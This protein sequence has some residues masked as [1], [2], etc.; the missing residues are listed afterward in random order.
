MQKQYNIVVLGGGE[1]GVG[2][3]LLAKQ[4]G[5]SV[6]VSDSGTLKENFKKEIIDAG[7]DFEEGKHSSEIITKAKTIIKSPGIADNSNIVLKAKRARIEIIGEI[8]YAS[9][10]TNAKFI[11]ITGSNGKTTTTLLIYHILKQAGLKVGLAGNIGQSLARQV[12]ADNPEWFVIELSSFQLDSMY[13]FH[14]HVAVM[15]NI[16]PDHLDRYD[17]NFDNYINSKFRILQNQNK[18]DYFIFFADDPIIRKKMSDIDIYATKLSFSL[19]NNTNNAAYITE[20]QLIIKHKNQELTM[21]YDELILKGKHNLCNAM[22]AALVAGVSN[23]KNEKIRESLANFTGVEHRLEEYLTIHGVQYI[24][25]SKATNIN[26]TWYALES[27]TRPTVWIVGGV[28][29]GNDYSELD[30][31]VSKNV[32]AI[33]CLGIDNKKIINHF[34]D[35]IDII[36]ETR[37]MKEAVYTAYKIA[38][39]NDV[40]LLS[41]ACASFDLFSNY[42]ERGRK[43]KE[44]VREL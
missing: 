12:I 10:S 18:L 6:F 2:A 7:I 32:K 42:E 16:T 20:K 1:S 43:F 11:A 13:S 34:K 28:D 3:A 14:A 41:P 9:R 39:P 40:V 8:E 36:I 21:F 38:V 30:S 27:M 33:I 24:N 15:M 19:N 5:E 44:A 22:A 17:N 37:S 25:D 4:N 31:V 26:S 35:K 23:I 29:K